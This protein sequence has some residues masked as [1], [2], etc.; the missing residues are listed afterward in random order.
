MQEGRRV[1]CSW[2]YRTEFTP[3]AGGVKKTRW[4]NFLGINYRANIWI[5]GHKVEDA[6]DVAGTY[7][8]FEFNVS[9]FLRQGKANA[10][11]VEGVAPGKDGLGVTWV[12]L[13]PPPPHKEIGIWEEVFLGASGGVAV[14]DPLL[15]SRPG[16]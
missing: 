13:N 16:A 4:L 14:R 12:D 2:W 7:R 10:L 6:N 1:R 15:G 5:N 9:K 3:P 8:S 11:A